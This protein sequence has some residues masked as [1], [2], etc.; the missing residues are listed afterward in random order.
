MGVQRIMEIE[1]GG[2]MNEFREEM[3]RVK[4]T[5]GDVNRRRISQ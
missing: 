1:K 5:D 2:V 3:G 4:Q